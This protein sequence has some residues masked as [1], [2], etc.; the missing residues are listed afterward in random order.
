VFD[1]SCVRP[2]HAVA[3]AEVASWSPET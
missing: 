3:S 1:T 2:L